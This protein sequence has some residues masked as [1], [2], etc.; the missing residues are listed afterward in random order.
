M[1]ELSTYCR[2]AQPPTSRAKS[3]TRSFCVR[4]HCN[5]LGTQSLSPLS[6][7]PEQRKRAKQSERKRV[8]ARDGRIDKIFVNARLGH[9]W[10]GDEIPERF[11]RFL[12]IAPPDVR[13]FSERAKFGVIF[14]TAPFEGKK[15]VPLKVRKTSCKW[16]Q[17]VQTPPL[18]TG[19]VKTRQG[20]EGDTKFISLS[21]RLGLNPSR[22]IRHRYDELTGVAV[23]AGRDCLFMRQ[24]PPDTERSFDGNDN[25]VPIELTQPNYLRAEKRHFESVF[26]GLETELKRAARSASNTV[27]LST[28]KTESIALWEVEIYWEFTVPDSL[29]YFAKIANTLEAYGRRNR[30][31]EHGTDEGREGNGKSYICYLNKSEAIKIYAKTRDRVRIEVT[32]KPRRNSRLLPSYEANGLPAVQPLLDTLRTKAAARVNHLLSF[33]EDYEGNQP[34]NIARS[35]GFISRWF[36]CLGHSESSMGLLDLVQQGQVIG[37]KKY[38]SREDQN[39][40]RRSREKGLLKYSSGVYYPVAS[41]EINSEFDSPLTESTTSP[42]SL[43][44]K[45]ETQAVPI[46]FVNSSFATLLADGE[47]VPPSPPNLPLLLPGNEE[48]CTK[49]AG[50]FFGTGSK[51]CLTKPRQ[52]SSIGE[53]PLW[54][55]LFRRRRLQ[56]VLSVHGSIR[57]GPR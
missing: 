7:C 20:G 15:C 48:R 46:R 45:T 21:A 51:T 11:R 13:S 55:P 4:Q 16:N 22:A 14:N 2:V 18:F 3:S 6:H 9:L 56:P 23:S 10:G 12:G 53:V 36:Q 39:T 40:L 5:E 8:E 35:L 34:K 1:L 50:W 49:V 30:K 57:A 38:L 54:F 26:T 52:F 32:Q 42:N 25:F 29:E 37:G 17:E 28:I 44:H 24:A 47:R 31:R 27:E 19:E 41:L 43:I 33:L